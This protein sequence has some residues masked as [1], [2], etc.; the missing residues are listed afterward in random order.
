MSGH[1]DTY[2]YLVRWKNYKMNR[3]AHMYT[4]I[5]PHKKKKYNKNEI[6]V[7]IL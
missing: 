5:D 3:Y 2:L 7:N 4:N 1:I 6:K